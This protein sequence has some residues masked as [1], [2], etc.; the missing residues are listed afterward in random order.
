MSNE[1]VKPTRHEKPADLLA[2]AR[3]FEEES[4]APELCDRFGEWISPELADLEERFD[5]LVTPQ[6]L[7]QHLKRG[8]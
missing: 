5:H 3:L 7:Q 6:S 4:L 8:R 2:S 1:F